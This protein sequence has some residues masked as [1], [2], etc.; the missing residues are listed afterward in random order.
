MNKRL[1][2]SLMAVIILAGSIITYEF[3]KRKR[4]L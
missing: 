4:R 2:K 1:N 3:H